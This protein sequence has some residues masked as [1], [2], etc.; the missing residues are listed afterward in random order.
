MRTFCS[1]AG[2]SHLAID[3]SR[4]CESHGAKKKVAGEVPRGHL[5]AHKRGY[6]VAWRRLRKM[7]LAEEPFCM[8]CKGNASEE[9]DHI[10]PKCDGGGN[11]RENLQG[12]CRECHQKKTI[13]D[14]GNEERSHDNIRIVNG[15]PYAGKRAYVYSQIRRND[16][17]FDWD[18]VL[19]ALIPVDPRDITLGMSVRE[20]VVKH[21][22]RINESRKAFIILTDYAGANDLAEE[23][24]GKLIIID[25]G[26][27]AALEAAK[28][29]GNRKLETVINSWYANKTAY[30]KRYGKRQDQ[31]EVGEI[32]YG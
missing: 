3:G 29:D 15:P 19:A 10:T 25:N 23:T 4:K 9:V 26:Q 31:I 2:C 30:I 24:G 28:K 7:V 22:K 5:S 14:A 12:I 27:D 16:I 8:V 21:A 17:V 1:H 32:I 6:G 20:T 18:K 11:D 13:Q